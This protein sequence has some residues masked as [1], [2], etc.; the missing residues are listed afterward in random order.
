MNILKSSSFLYKHPW[1][2]LCFAA[3]LVV[4]VLFAQWMG[5]RHR[6]E[7]AD[8]ANAQ[9]LV[10]A[11]NQITLDTAVEY[12]GDQLHSCTL[13]DG[14]TLADGAPALP[15]IPLLQ[16]SVQVLALWAAYASWD[17]PVLL[18]FSSRAPPLA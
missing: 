17:A 14:M 8:Q 9:R 3:M 16:T 12:T 10:L 2:R 13:F 18:H 6:I 1:P 15:F 7:H 11:A 5:V 4:V